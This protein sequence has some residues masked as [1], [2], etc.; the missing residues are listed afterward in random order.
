M[1]RTLDLLSESAPQER[2]MATL[3]RP[4][5]VQIHQR[6][7]WTQEMVRDSSPLRRPY[8]KRSKKQVYSHYRQAEETSEEQKQNIIVTDQLVFIEELCGSIYSQRQNISRQH[9]WGESLSQGIGSR[10][11]TSCDSSAKKR[12]VMLGYQRNYHH[13]NSCVEI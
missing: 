13:T 11:D 5:T 9:Q 6:Q 8:W 4:Q 10:I 12:R 2:T 7:R 1:Q 3:L